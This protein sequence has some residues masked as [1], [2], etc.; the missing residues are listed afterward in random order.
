[1][2]PTDF[3]FDICPHCAVEIIDDF[4]NIDEEGAVP[5]HYQLVCPYCGG[6]FDLIFTYSIMTYPTP[7]CAA[8]LL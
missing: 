6:S 7:D 3:C 8:V 5:G 1:M 4:L 2:S